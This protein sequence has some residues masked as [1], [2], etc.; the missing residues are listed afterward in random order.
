MS[1]W[2]NLTSYRKSHKKNNIPGIIMAGW[3]VTADIPL[4]YGR[5]LL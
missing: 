4:K 1:A 3:D 2:Q 5:T